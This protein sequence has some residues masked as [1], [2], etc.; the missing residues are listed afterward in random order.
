MGSVPLGVHAAS[1]A[2][3]VVRRLQFW[4]LLLLSKELEQCACRLLGCRARRFKRCACGLKVD[5]W[6]LNVWKAVTPTARLGLPPLAQLREAAAQRRLLS[7]EGAAL[8][9]QLRE[10]LRSCRHVRSHLLYACQLLGLLGVGGRGIYA[11]LSQLDRVGR[12]GLVPLPLHRFHGLH[13]RV[14]G[15]LHLIGRAPLLISDRLESALRRHAPLLGC[16]HGLTHRVP[17]LA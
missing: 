13:G 2:L 9:P 8:L 6:Q 10:R 12:N 16:R 4:F 17:K 1:V 7:G 11:Q 3:R 14:E 15:N 5:I